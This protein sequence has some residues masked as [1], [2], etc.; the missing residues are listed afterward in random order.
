L[1]EK[2]IRDIF[3]KI[4]AVL[5]SQNIAGQPGDPYSQLSMLAA[6]LLEGALINLARMSGST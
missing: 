5:A 1:D 4:N 3:A 2:E 6:Q